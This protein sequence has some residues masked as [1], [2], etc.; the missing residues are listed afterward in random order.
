ME[1]HRHLG[2]GFLERVYHE[3]LPVELGARG[4]GCASQVEFP[5]SYKG[6]FVGSYFCDLLVETRVVCEIKALDVLNSVHQAQLINYLKASGFKIGLLLNF[7][8]K[9]LQ[10]K[11][12]AL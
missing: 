7:G 6:Q 5:V 1:V 11:R 4:L 9:S 3:A 8:A 12:I 10:V 2:P